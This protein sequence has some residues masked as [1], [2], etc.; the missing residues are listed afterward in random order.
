LRYLAFAYE[1]GLGVARDQRQAARL[2]S[3]QAQAA[4][5]Y[6]RAAAAGDMQAQKKVGGIH[7]ESLTVAD[8]VS[9]FEAV[10]H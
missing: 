3:G 6:E 1:Q 8:R 7:A 9:H 5:F 4:E 2:Q 10:R